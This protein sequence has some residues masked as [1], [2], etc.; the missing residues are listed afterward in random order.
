MH[1]ARPNT[2]EVRHGGMSTMSFMYG[3]FILPGESEGL[4]CT[5]C[6]GDFGLNPGEPNRR[7]AAK[8][9]SAAYE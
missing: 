9:L 4:A 3:L 5:V 1:V 2:T 7:K 8:P 6:T